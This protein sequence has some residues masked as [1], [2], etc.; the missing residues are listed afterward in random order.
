[1]LSQQILYE[2]MLDVID[3]DFKLT[4]DE[5]EHWKKQAR[6]WRLPYW[7]WARKQ[8]YA[9]SFAV[10]EV[11]TVNNVNIFPPESAGD[12]YGKITEVD[13][14]GRT[15]AYPNPLYGFENPEVDRQGNPRQ[16]GYM[17][18]GKRLFSLD[19]SYGSGDVKTDH[20]AND[21]CNPVSAPVLPLHCPY[22]D[23]QGLIVTTVESHHE[24]GPLGYSNHSHQE[25]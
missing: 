2:N 20:P 23:D 25:I 4:G 7:D 22:V 16:F 9:E 21:N 14:I 5:A 6:E 17:P 18:P 11:L 24:H 15:T 13:G 8:K 1:M 3:N 19:N 10:P 12:K